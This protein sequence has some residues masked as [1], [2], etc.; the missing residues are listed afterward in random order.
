MLNMSRN[1]IDKG[2]GNRIPTLN[3]NNI[4][5]T[6]SPLPIILLVNSSWITK[7][8]GRKLTIRPNPVTKALTEI[9]LNLN[10][11][12]NNTSLSTRSECS[13]TS[14]AKWTKIWEGFGKVTVVWWIKCKETKALACEQIC[15]VARV[16]NPEMKIEDSRI[17]RRKWDS[18]LEKD[19]E[20]WPL[21]SYSN[22]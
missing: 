11:G 13:L 21:L 9:K 19:Q 16:Y 1:I 18:C 8:S 22:L 2:I 12:T 5:T 4:E 14:P 15:R 7:Q 17:Q 6:L 10:W 3:I 20:H